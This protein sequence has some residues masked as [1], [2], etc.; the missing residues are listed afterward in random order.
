MNR[1]YF[2][3][4]QCILLVSKYCLQITAGHNG[5]AA[6]SSS[7]GP[8]SLLGRSRLEIEPGAGVLECLEL[9]GLL[10]VQMQQQ[11]LSLHQ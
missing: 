7:V 1:E 5:A 11:Y 2:S 9:K 8:H 6:N 4:V 10:L 3:F